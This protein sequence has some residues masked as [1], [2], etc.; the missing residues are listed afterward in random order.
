MWEGSLFSTPSPAFIDCRLLDNSHSDWCEM[1]PHCGFDLHFSDNEWCW[2][3]FHV[4]FSHLY[5][6]FGEMSVYFFGTFLIGSFIFL[7]L[8]AG[9]AC[10]FLRLTLCQLLCSTPIFLP[11]EFCGQRSLAGYSPWN[12]K[13]LD[14]TEWLTLSLSHMLSTFSFLILIEGKTF[15]VY[16]WHASVVK[17][18]KQRF[19]SCSLK[20]KC[21][22]NTLNMR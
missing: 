15:Q 22:K 13:E 2:A 8:S 1:V 5:V 11:G 10:I 3:S 14:T 7:E 6:F 20:V 18:V 16:K 17:A 9:V 19:S 21:L 4:F 12:H